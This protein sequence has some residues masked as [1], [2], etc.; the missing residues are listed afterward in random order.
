MPLATNPAHG[1]TT[2]TT[3]YQKAA[4][5]GSHAGYGVGAY[6]PTQPMLTY[7]FTQF[8]HSQTTGAKM[9]IFIERQLF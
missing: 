5:Y 4:V 9:H 2:A 6:H 1:V 3:Q 8:H 7:C